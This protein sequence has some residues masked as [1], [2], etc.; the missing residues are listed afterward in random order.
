MPKAETHLVGESAVIDE[1]G[2]VT[3]PAAILAPPERL[4]SARG[5]AWGRPVGKGL[6]HLL[7]RVRVYGAEHV[8]QEGSAL[9]AANHTGIVDGPLMF[10]TCP[11]PV[12]ALTKDEMFFWPLGPVL[13]GAGQI[14]V[15]R[16]TLD[17]PALRACLG[18]LRDGRLLGI[19]PEGSRGDGDFAAVKGGAA[20]LALR[21]GA[22]I[23]PLVC[24]GVRRTNGSVSLPPRPRTPMDVVYGPPF[25]VEAPEPWGRYLPRRIV[26]K[27]TEQIH[28][29]LLEHLAY[30]CELTGRASPLS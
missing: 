9:I 24:F 11:R 30:A 13:T 14:P 29:R 8:P 16:T 5:A 2:Q 6:L 27:V 1:E 23:V 7:W 25:R 12:H 21:T 10:G 26:A 18:V 3:D 19:Y 17:V 15:V 20:W 28:T 4:P 22:P